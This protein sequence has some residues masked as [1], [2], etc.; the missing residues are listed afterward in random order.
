MRF[1]DLLLWLYVWVD[2]RLFFLAQSIARITR[3]VNPYV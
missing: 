2:V 3:K 1:S